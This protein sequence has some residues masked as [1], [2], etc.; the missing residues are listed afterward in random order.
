MSPAAPAFRDRVDAGRQL[1]AAL[2]RYRTRDALVLALPRGGVPVADEVARELGAP[3][4]VLV[5]RKL[6]APGHPELG[7]GAVAEGG[8]LHLDDVLI[9]H[10]GVTDE[11][12]RRVTT[13]ALTEMDRR[14]AAYRGDRAATDVTGRTVVLVDDGL[15]TGVTAR[16]AIRSLRRRSPRAIVLAV[17]VCAAPTARELR[18]EVDDLVCL[19][20]P[21]DLRAVGL[22]YRDFDQTTDAEVVA[23]LERARA[24]V[25]DPLPSIS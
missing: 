14:L 23:R 6:G 11:H 25:G 19:V 8:A 7:V 15:A 2:S 4:D 22:W 17:P 24:P 12:L 20:A 5:A 9:R 21:E 1:A 10:L 13:E 3:L 16:A 18:G